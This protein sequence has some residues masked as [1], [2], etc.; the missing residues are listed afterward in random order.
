MLNRSTII[1]KIPIIHTEGKATTFDTM[2]DF[3]QNIHLVEVIA[4]NTFHDKYSYEVQSKND[5]KQNAVVFGGH[6][7][8]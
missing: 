5:S 6:S 2:K 4:D 7:S 3:V 1:M 8:V